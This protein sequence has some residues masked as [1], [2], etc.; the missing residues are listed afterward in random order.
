MPLLPCT[1]AEAEQHAERSM[2]R[3]AYDFYK[4]SRGLHEN[5]PG[6]LAASSF[7][8]IAQFDAWHFIEMIAPR[9]LLMI[10]GA[11]AD[12]LAQ[13]EAAI[14]KAREPKE[15]Y[16]VDGASH[17]DLYDVRVPDV[18]PKLIEFFTENL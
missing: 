9:P 16:V 6:T 1:L 7:D 14:A 10:A 4:T 12:T 15:L 3:E 17:V 8:R 5:A 11:D 13:S 2:F 18:A